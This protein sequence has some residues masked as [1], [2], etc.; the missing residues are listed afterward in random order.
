MGAIDM[1]KG[2]SG[3]ERAEQWFGIFS[4]IVEDTSEGLILSD[5]EGYLLFVNNAFALMHGYAAKR[6]VG[7]H[8]CSLHTPEQMPAVEAAKRQTLDTGEF[9]G[10]I[11]HVRRDGRTFPTLT[12]SCL[13][14]EEAGEP[15]CMIGM[16]RDI[17]DLKRA[18]DSLR[19]SEERYRSLFENTND[20]IF[21]ADKE[22]GVIVEANR[23]AEKLTGSSKDEIIGVHHSKLHPPQHAEY[24]KN[25]FC[26]CTQ[27]GHILD[28]E[29]EVM[30]RDGNVVSVLINASVITLDGKEMIQAI[31][32]DITDEKRMLELREEIASR[33]LIERAKGI[34]MDYHKI[35]EKEAMRRL[36]KESR[37]QRKKIKEIARTVISLEFSL[38]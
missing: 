32:R 34:L 37:R 17:T 20:A 10:E 11:W 2:I 14:L 7:R 13:F 19:E 31:F 5:L 1:A 38:H 22:T 9:S 15:I 25:R 8:L 21:L 3:C 35:S 24:Y 12:H 29:A 30:K 23:Q 33:K 18:N 26:N 16:V 28:F 4:K 27:T 6:L 36:Q